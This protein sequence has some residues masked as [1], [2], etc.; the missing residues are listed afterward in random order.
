MKKSL[1]LLLLPF[2]SLQAFSN[3]WQMFDRRLGMFIHWGV[4][5]V[6]GYH[7]QE[8]MKLGLSKAEY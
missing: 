4:Y 7:E 6:G 5:S 2:V 1:F 8:W 3:P